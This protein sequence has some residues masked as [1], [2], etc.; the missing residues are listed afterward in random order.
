MSGTGDVKRDSHSDPAPQ[1]KDRSDW[2][3][4]RKTFAEEACEITEEMEV[5]VARV[6]RETLKSPD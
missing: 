6:I 2:W 3:T 4:N 5:E 1:K